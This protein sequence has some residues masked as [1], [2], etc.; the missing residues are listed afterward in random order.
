MGLNN[1]GARLDRVGRYRDA[2]GVETES[3]G[4]YRE[5]A[6]RDPDLYQNQYRQSLSALRRKYDQ[7]GWHDDAMLHHLIDPPDQP[8]STF[9]IIFVTIRCRL[10]AL[11]LSMRTPGGAVVGAGHCSA[12][13]CQSRSRPTGLLH[14]CAVRLNPDTPYLPPH[15]DLRDGVITRANA[16]FIMRELPFDQIPN[17]F[18]V[19]RQDYTRVTS[20]KDPYR[21]YAS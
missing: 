9:A 10:L 18:H 21:G 15:P 4:I 13:A 12:A 17:R 11:T 1:L 5:P 2:L 8:P 6:S 14:S 16:Y 3:A 7:R 19:T 20:S